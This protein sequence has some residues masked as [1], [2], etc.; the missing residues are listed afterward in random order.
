[1]PVP[2]PL[3]RRRDVRCVIPC[4]FSTQVK[5]PNGTRVRHAC[6]CPKIQPPEVLKAVEKADAKAQNLKRRRVAWYRNSVFVS[7]ASILI[8]LGA[9][10]L[11]IGA[12][13]FNGSWF[14]DETPVDSSEA[15]VAPVEETNPESE[16]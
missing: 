5:R 7:Q 6:P 12:L 13:A 15:A 14:V 4:S 8:A 1:M 10:I 11:S 16:S 3:I 9:V 2:Y